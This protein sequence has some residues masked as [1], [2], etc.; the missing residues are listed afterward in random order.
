MT[1]PVQP[2]ENSISMNPSSLPH[3]IEENVVLSMRLWKKQ[4]EEEG[5][6]EE[7]DLEETVDR[8]QPWTS[9]SFSV[10]LQ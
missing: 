5:S 3:S 7:E 2:E 1:G 4:D 8:A 10:S 6:V 9:G